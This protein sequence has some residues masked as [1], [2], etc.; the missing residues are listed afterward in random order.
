MKADG[1]KRKIIRGSGCA[2]GQ[3]DDEIHMRFQNDVVAG[4]AAGGTNANLPVFTVNFYVHEDIEAYGN[5][6]RRDTIFPQVFRKVTQATAV[7]V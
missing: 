6:I 3:A 2:C 5:L 1:L 7:W 4:F